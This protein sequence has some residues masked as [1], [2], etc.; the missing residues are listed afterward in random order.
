MYLY[1]KDLNEPKYQFLIKIGEDEGK[2]L[3]ND[4]KAFIE[5]SNVMDDV[6]N[7]ID[8]YKRTRKRKILMIFDD[9]IAEIKTNKKLQARTIYQMQEIEISSIYHN[10]LFFCSK[11]SQ[12]KFYTLPNN[13]D[14]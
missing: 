13:K 5:H 11:G 12:I 2:K 9:K 3:L 4:T 8:D 14:S 1:A 10:I 6:Q 7:N